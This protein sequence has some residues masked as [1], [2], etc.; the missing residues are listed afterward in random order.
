MNILS[1]HIAKDLG[2]DDSVS[3]LRDYTLFRDNTSYSGLYGNEHIENMP[4]PPLSL[5]LISDGTIKSS[6]SSN[7]RSAIQSSQLV[8]MLRVIKSAKMIGIVFIRNIQN[9]LEQALS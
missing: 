8:F 2:Q 7:M 9:I 3:I 6:F 1:Q 4:S 5:M